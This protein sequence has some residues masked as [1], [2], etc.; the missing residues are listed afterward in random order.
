MW[1]RYRRSSR[2][3]R[4]RAERAH[5][6]LDI[7]GLRM[8]AVLTVF[9]NHLWGWPKGGFVG[10]DV[11]FVISGFLIT[12]NLLRMAET[13]GTVSFWG[14]YKN[15]I[16]RIVPA[17]TV[18]LVITYLASV[19]VFQPFRSDQVGI[20]A[21]FAFIFWANWHFA[22]EGTDY[23]H[24]GDAVSPL[25]HYWSLSIEEQFYFVWPALIFVVSVVVVRKAWTHT[26]RMQ[27]AAAVM[28]VVVAASLAWAIYETATSPTWAYFN[29]FARV[30]ELG[31]G[32]LM[33]IAVSLLT[34][35]P[36]M[37][38]PVL[39]WVG[40][41]LI[42]ASLFLIGDGADGFPAPWVILPV[43]GTALVIAAGVGGEPK[44]QEFLRNPV[45]THIG[46]ISYSLY[47][48]H[49]PVIVLLGALMDPGLYFYLC[50]VGL[51]F[52]LAIASYHFVENPIRDAGMT[53]NR[54]QKRQGRHWREKSSQYA[55]VSAASLLLIGLIGYILRPDSYQPDAA[56]PIGTAAAAD[57]TQN[58]TPAPPMPPLAA[59]LSDQIIDSLKATDWPQ[60]DPPM[61]TVISTPAA[62]PEVL[63]CGGPTPPP[64]GAC[65]WGSDT[66]PTRAVLIGDSIAMSYVGALR[67]IAQDSGGQLQVHTEA[68]FACYFID[69]TIDNVD[70]KL[71]D[72][73]PARKQRGIDYINAMEPDVV[74]ISHTYTDKKIN[75][76]DHMVTPTEWSA[77]LGKF[78]ETFRGSVKKIVFLSPP[79]SDV[80][81]SDCYGNGSHKPA[82]CISRVTEDWMAMTRAERDLAKSVGG[83]WVDSRPWFC[84][85]GLCPS[86]V[87]NILVKKDAVH[88]TPAYGHKV[89]PVIAESLQADGV[90]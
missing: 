33:A 51:S 17:A 45:A 8:V 63:A 56:P 38:R 81:I 72:A 2:H 9:A 10:V 29:T 86:F 70:V 69:D 59:A 27:L 73:C 71:M 36:L 75:G 85:N 18:V 48:V 88:M 24:A 60:F 83:I 28:G 39:S 90:F 61:D 12:G 4:R 65:T 3:R 44:Y 25:Q 42:T 41:L 14:F 11:F 5:K 52:A 64:A 30:W 89:Y 21:L 32:A 80:S 47:L 66:A 16:R 58:A 15:R 55:A 37:S 77:E 23:F 40:L 43:A 57:T 84:H 7:Q 1:K 46:G 22:I 82:N 78:I 79:P 31:I 13:T 35:I 54:A 53:K 49:W 34:R 50:V 76:T 68:Q 67:D 26:H 19:L 62:A 20:D 87:G 6:R 74:F